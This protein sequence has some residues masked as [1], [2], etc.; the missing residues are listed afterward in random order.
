MSIADRVAVEHRHLGRELE[1]RAPGVAVGDDPVEVEL[2]QVGHLEVE[3]RADRLVGDPVPDPPQLR[4]CRRGGRSA[5]C[6]SSSRGAPA[7]R[8]SRRSPTTAIL[9]SSAMPLRT[10][11]IGSVARKREVEDHLLGGVVGAEPVLEVA[12]VD[13]DLDRHAGVDQ[14]DQRRRHADVVGAAPVGGAGEPGDVGGQAA[15]DDQHRLLRT[16]PKSPKASTI[17]SSV[18]SLLSVSAIAHREHG[19][20]DPVIAEVASIC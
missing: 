1:R 6:S 17:C 8:R 16:S 12:V 4:R 11:A 18:A 3:H 14:P 9:T 19:E 13:R 7:A 10:W 2:V 5:V 20:G 15:A